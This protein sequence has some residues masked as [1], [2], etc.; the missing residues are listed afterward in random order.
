LG[1]RSPACVGIRLGRLDQMA[2][3]AQGQFGLHSPAPMG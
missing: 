2:L 1:D 3:Q